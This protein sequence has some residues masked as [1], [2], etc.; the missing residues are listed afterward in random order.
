MDFSLVLAVPFEQF[1]VNLRLIYGDQNLAYRFDQSTM[2]HC[3]GRWI[4]V[5]HQSSVFIYWPERGDQLIIMR[6]IPGMLV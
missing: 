2:S 1:L 3:F 4:E 5:L 6:E